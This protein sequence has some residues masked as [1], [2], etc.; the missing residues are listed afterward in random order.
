[1][2]TRHSTQRLSLAATLIWVLAGLTTGRIGKA[3]QSLSPS[4]SAFEVVSIKPTVPGSRGGPGPVVSTSPGRL[5]AR[6]TLR[7]FL[8][9]AYGVHSFQI[10]GG[11]AWTASDRFDIEGKQ[12]EGAANYS[13]QP[14]LLR[15]ALADRFRLVFHRETNQLSVLVLVA[16]GNGPK[17]VASRPDDEPG[18]RGGYGQLTAVKLSMRGLAAL[19]SQNT[20]RVVLDRTNVGGEFNF[21]LMWTPDEFQ[22]PDP[23]GL[24]PANTDGTSLFTA[25]QEQLGLKLE[26]GKGSVEMLVIDHVEKPSKN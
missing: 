11:P 6:G 12:P 20:V 2:M 8:A 23:R 15:T 4:E 7:F 26:P 10:S 17:L 13:Q 5:F 1:M 14:A 25:L 21:T 9:Y 24:R 22:R 19:L 3:A 16:A 18:T